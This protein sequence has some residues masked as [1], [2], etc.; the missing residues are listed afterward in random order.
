[1]PLNSIEEDFELDYYLQIPTSFKELWKKE[2]AYDENSTSY[3][4]HLVEQVQ[5]EWQDAQPQNPNRFG[6][7]EPPQCQAKF[8]L[9]NS[10]WHSIMNGHG[11]RFARQLLEVSRRPYVMLWGE[12]FEYVAK[13]ILRFIYVELV[14]EKPE[15]IVTYPLLKEAVSQWHSEHIL[16]PNEQP[17]RLPRRFPRLLRDIGLSSLPGLPKPGRPRRKA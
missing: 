3:L 15:H 11:E 1:V 8:E 2:L 4:W 17:I 14:R 13:N 10:F 16:F 7:S 9:L 6:P 12:R 5:R